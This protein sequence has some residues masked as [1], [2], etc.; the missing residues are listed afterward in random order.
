MENLLKQVKELEIELK[1]QHRRKDREGSSNDPNYTGGNTGESSHCSDSC[2]S[3]DKFH[4]TMGRHHDSPHRDRRG[5]YNAALDAMSRAL[6]RAARSPFLNE[7]EHTE[8]PRCF[9]QPPFTSY[10]GKTNPVEHVSHYI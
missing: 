4:E 5:Y 9:N 7:I 8:M 10:D 1:G 3:R 2:R 6:R